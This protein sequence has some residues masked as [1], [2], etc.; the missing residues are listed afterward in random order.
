LSK[1]KKEYLGKQSWKVNERIK[2]AAQMI[3]T[4]QMHYIACQ[5]HA[6]RFVILTKSLSTFALFLASLDVLANG[7]LWKTPKV[8]TR[9]YSR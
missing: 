5:V 1:T 3:A 7:G 6:G 9:R 2:V 8:V 4:Q